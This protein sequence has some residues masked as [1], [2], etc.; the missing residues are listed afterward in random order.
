MYIQLQMNKKNFLTLY[1]RTVVIY[2]IGYG[3]IYMIGY[4][5]TDLFFI[6]YHVEKNKIGNLGTTFLR[7]YL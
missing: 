7:Y 4:G 2:M 6:L 3:F 1:K 5:V